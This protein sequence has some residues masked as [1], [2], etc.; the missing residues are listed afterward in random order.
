MKRLYAASAVLGL[1]L[2]A[3]TGLAEAHP[4]TDTGAIAFVSDRDRDRETAADN[5]SLDERS[6]RSARASGI[7]FI[8]DRDSPSPDQ[9]TDEVYLYDTSTGRTSRL[10]TNAVEESFPQISPNGRYLSYLSNTGIDVC[11]L[12][13]TAGRWSCGA[14]RGVVSNP[15]PGQGGRFV[16]TP[17]GRSI[18]YG[19]LDPVGGDIDVFSVNL[20]NL[21]P[22]RN[23][24]QE[25]PDEPAAFDG[26][27]SVSPNGQFVVYGRTVTGGGDLYR[28]RID[29]SHPVAVT[30][31]ST[32]SEFGPAYSP[33]GS[34]IAFH[35]NRRNP[36]DFDIYLMRPR[37]ESA[38]NPAFDLTA[39]LTARGETPSRERFPT[40]SPN[41]AKIAFWWHVTPDGFTDGEIYT[42]RADGTQIQNLTANNPTNPAAQP[43]GDILPAWGTP[44]R[45]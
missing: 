35:S 26:Q 40:W 19:G 27:P 16:W 12:S 15:A 45:R 6:A 13:L 30:S 18:V 8:S 29:G 24:T 41:G 31:T 5:A 4:R 1:I 14:A 28:R 43:I 37:P 11:P 7:V 17:D 25:A 32:A 3:P 39:E 2:T 33:D 38:A 36:A 44:R 42:M 34:R 9:V 23:L 21:K 10:T 20:F 22:A